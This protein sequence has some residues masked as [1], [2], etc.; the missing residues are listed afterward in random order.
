M[1]SLF[2]SVVTT[3]SFRIHLLDFVPRPTRN[4]AVGQPYSGQKKD[5]RRVCEVYRQITENLVDHQNVTSEKFILKFHCFSASWHSGNVFL[6]PGSERCLLL[7]VSV[8]IVV[9]QNGIRG[10]VHVVN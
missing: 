10:V 9:Q 3:T 7:I 4:T 6:W 5:I 1:C 8:V 2:Y